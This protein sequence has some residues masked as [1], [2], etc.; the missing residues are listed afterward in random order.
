MSMIQVENLTFSYPSGYDNIFENVSFQI[1]T[2][3]KLGFIGRNGRG[4]TT[5]FNLLLGK[6]EYQG[7]I[8]SS[9]QFDYFPYVIA[10]KN[11]LTEEILFEICPFAERWEIIRELSYLEVHEDVILNP[12]SIL[13]GGE[14]TKVLLAALFLN[15][16]HFLL[17][18]EPTNHL[19]AK[20]RELISTYL[21]NKKGFILVSHDRCFFRWMC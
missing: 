9:V 3:W 1:D 21:K 4:K 19:D 15:D 5:F 14:Q 12:F 6:Y 20:A 18:D 7:K 11:R 16:E 17:I 13:S 10:D 2:D 8:K